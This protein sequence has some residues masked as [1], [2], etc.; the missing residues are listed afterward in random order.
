MGGRVEPALDIMNYLIDNR[1]PATIFITG[2]ILDSENTDAGR[3]VLALVEANQD[4]FDLGNHSYSHPDFTT[5][6]AQQMTNEIRDTEAAIARYSDMNPQP[7]FRPPFGA[8]DS[9]VLAVLGPLGYTRTMYWEIDTIDWLAT[10]DGGPTA[11]SMTAK[12]VN[13]AQS[14][15]IV[16]M[17]LGGYHTYEA[18]PGMIAGLRA[19]GLEPVKLST[20]LD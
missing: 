20:M 18:L 14:G 3:Q 16:L 7:Y 13:N 5:L 15:S 4:L 17:H 12:V 2:A 1:I 6:T 11:A 8:Y 19:K 9:N 10:E